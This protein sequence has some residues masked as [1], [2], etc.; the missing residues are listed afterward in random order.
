[1]RAPRSEGQR[2]DNPWLSRSAG[3][4][5]LSTC[6]WPFRYLAVETEIVVQDC[7]AVPAYTH[8]QQQQAF[9]AQAIAVRAAEGVDGTARPTYQQPKQSD[10]PGQA[11]T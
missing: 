2:R 4:G 9:Q 8:E 5:N 10:E 11:I 6:Y 3:A 7:A 1:M